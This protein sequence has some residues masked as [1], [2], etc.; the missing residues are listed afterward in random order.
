MSD[1]TQK[2]KFSIN[3]FFSKCD[4]CDLVTLT[5]KILNGKLQFLCSEKSVA[6]NF[7]K[8]T[9]KYLSLS[10]FFIE[11]AYLGLQLY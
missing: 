7:S 3:D 8:V 6:G 5:E 4:Q 2:T 9:A 1:T 11:V 10:L